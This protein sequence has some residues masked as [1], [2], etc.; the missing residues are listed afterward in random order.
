MVI[1]I[2]YCNELH[3]GYQKWYRYV[4]INIVQC[5]NHNILQYIA[6]GWLS[7]PQ[8]VIENFGS[9]RHHRLLYPTLPSPQPQILNIY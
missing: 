5:D 4:I 1:T 7:G 6:L 9:Y 2:I 8:E 3:F